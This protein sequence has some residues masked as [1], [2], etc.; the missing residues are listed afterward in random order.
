MPEPDQYETV[1]YVSG[2]ALAWA[3]SLLSLTPFPTT[4]EDLAP[5]LQALINQE[6]NRVLLLVERALVDQIQP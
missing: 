6:N 2:R 5:H 4:P 3:R 1:E